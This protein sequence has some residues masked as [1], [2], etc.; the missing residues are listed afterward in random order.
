MCKCFICGKEIITHKEEHYL[1]YKCYTEFNKKLSIQNES[2][3]QNCVLN[4]KKNTLH[5]NEEKQNYLIVL[6][7]I[8]HVLNEFENNDEKINF[9]LKNNI[10]FIKNNFENDFNENLNKI[11]HLE[12]TIKQKNN[13]ISLLKEKLKNNDITKIKALKIFNGYDEFKE[14]TENLY[15]INK[16]Y[17]PSETYDERIEKIKNEKYFNEIKDLFNNS[18]LNRAKVQHKQV[19]SFLDTMYIMNKIFNEVHDDKIKKEIKIITEY[20]IPDCSKQRVDYMLIF[21]NSILLIECTKVESYKK[22]KQKDEEKR[23]QVKKYE[24][25]IKDLIK[26]INNKSNIEVMGTTC[27]Y[28]DES[29]EENLQINKKVINKIKTFIE[30]A[31]NQNNNKSAFEILNNLEI[32]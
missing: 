24:E 22:I 26:S 28:L 15:D 31:N 9:L 7:Y 18:E 2:E 16:W 23:E 8:L 32:L 1:C 30:N 6:M 29:C 13:E 17:I 20:V 11:K 27:C 25:R 21:R 19:V 5:T 3:I 14:Y 4:Y 12:E 10:V